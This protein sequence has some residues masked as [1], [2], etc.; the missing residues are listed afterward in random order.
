MLLHLILILP[1]LR[2]IRTSQIGQYQR[3]EEQ[4]GPSGQNS[5]VK[6]GNSRGPGIMTYDFVLSNRLPSPLMGIQ[7]IIEHTLNFLLK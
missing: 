6:M 7:L 5:H 2:R 3:Y 1:R 4:S